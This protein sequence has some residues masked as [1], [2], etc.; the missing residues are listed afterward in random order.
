MILLN[1]NDDTY[2]DEAKVLIKAFYPFHE[3]R[4]CMKPEDAE[5]VTEEKE[6]QS[7]NE[8]QADVVVEVVVSKEWASVLIGG[9]ET[10]IC[11]EEET[12]KCIYDA[13][14]TALYQA[15]HK[16]TKKDLPWGS[17]TGVRPTKI[18]MSRL[19]E[20]DDETSIRH[21]LSEKYFV[22]PAKMDLSLD[23]AKREK[24]LLKKLDYQNGYSLY[25]GVPFCPTT[26]LYCSFTSY[27][28]GMWRTKTDAYVDALIRELTYVAKQYQGKVLDTVYFGGGTPTTLEPEQL[29]RILRFLETH[30]DLSHVKELTVEAGRPDSVTREKLETLKKHKVSRISINPQTMNQK[31]LDLIGRRHT[32]EQ[33]VDAFHM[34]RDCGFDNINMDLIVGLPGESMED[35]RYTMEEV[36]KLAPENLTVHSLAIK[37]A[38]ALNLW[39]DK[40]KE[41]ILNTD[42]IITMTAEYA[43]NMGLHPYYLYR[44]K[45]MAGNFENVGYAK[46]GMEGLYNILIMEEVQTIVACGAGASTKIV[47]PKENRIERVEN[48]KDVK[49]YIERIDEM[50]DRKRK[51]FSC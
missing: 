22:S 46:E 7:T 17:L 43:R 6:E 28:I 31:T 23:V 4:V 12:K 27:P 13:L 36:R 47:F 44:Q 24:A 11:I 18:V 34:A 9:E 20:G 51:F 10:R 49:N 3:V 50:I 5:G 19:E 40:F 45:N 26:C 16:E 41:Q 39:K 37:R 48:V 1:I 15:L 35:V 30:F 42:E 8:S 32:V 21:F 33:V 25:V 29:D 14:K 2:C 38:A